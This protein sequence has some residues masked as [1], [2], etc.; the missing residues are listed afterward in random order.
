MRARRA[1]AVLFI[2]GLIFAADA[3]AGRPAIT[4]DASVVGARAFQ[5]ETWAHG[6]R[7]LV[8]HWL[9]GSYGPTDD[10]E[11]IVGG[12]WGA[13]LPD[14]GLTALGPLVEGKLLYRQIE[15]GGAP[16]VGAALGV[17]APLGNGALDIPGFHEYLYLI[18]SAS[19]FSSGALLL[20]A[21][22]GIS[23]QSGGNE[24]L[25]SALWSLG[26]ELF[27]TDQLHAVA[28]LFPADPLNPEASGA[29][30]VGLAYHLTQNFQLDAT[31]G[32]GLWGSLQPPFATLG[33]QW[34]IAP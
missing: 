5:L 7:T 29:A 28:D 14:K 15:H 13:S 27:F 30:Q 22:G 24:H 33:L 26:A 6:D 19:P 18:V 23:V 20:H 4:D 31:V 10:T 34:V 9:L 11:L 16:G 32:V 2:V 3:S 21:N 8:G 25:A 1:R 12:A 17:I